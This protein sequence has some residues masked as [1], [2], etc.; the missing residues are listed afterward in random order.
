MYP[1]WRVE[2]YRRTGLFNAIKVFDMSV[3]FS[4][5]VV[6]NSLLSHGLHMPGFPGLHHLPEFA[7]THVH[8]VGDATNHLVLII[9][10]FSCLQSFPASGP[11]LKSWLYTS[12]GQSFGASASAP[13]LPM[14]I[15]DWFPL[16]L[17]GLSP[18]SPRDC[19][20]SSTPQFK[21]ITSLVLSSL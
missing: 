19:Q 11:L 15:Q 10:F 18:C 21:S 5:S 14:N 8:R 7:Q 13:V 9:P 17:T 4:R 1:L 3:Q 6:S 20:E 2:R 16:G 12:G